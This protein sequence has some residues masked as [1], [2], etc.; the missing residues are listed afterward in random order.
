MVEYTTC[1]KCGTLRDV[2]EMTRK[3]FDRMVA[4]GFCFLCEK[5]NTRL[6]PAIEEQQTR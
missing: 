4:V 5:E 1:P 6:N 3:Q 2:Y